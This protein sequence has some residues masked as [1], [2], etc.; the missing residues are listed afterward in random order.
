MKNVL[1]IIVTELQRASQSLQT[2]LLQSL[3]STVTWLT[4]LGWEGHK[5]VAHQ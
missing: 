5:E 1:K 3:S 2:L 4:R